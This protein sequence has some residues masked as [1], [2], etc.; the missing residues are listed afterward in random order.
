MDFKLLKDLNSISGVSGD[1][2]KILDF[3][4]DYVLK[5]QQKWAFQPKIIRNKHTQDAILLVFGKPKTAVFAHVDTVGFTAGY[6][7]DLI[8]VGSPAIKKSDILVG[9]DKLG[10]FKCKVT[11][12]DNQWHYLLDRAIERGTPLS[13]KPHF[14]ETKDFVE[15]NY[16]DNRLGVFVAL[17][18][19]ETLKNGVIAFTTYEEV[20]GGNAEV[21]ANYLYNKFSICQS[22]ICDITWVT[23]GV[24]HH[25]GVVIS[26]RDSGI[27][28]RKY[29]QKIIELAQKSGIPFQV[30]VESAGGSDGNAI[31]KSIVPMDWCFIGAPE[32]GV[33]SYTETVSKADIESM[34]LLYRYLM[35]NL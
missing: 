17:Q 28:R 6:G 18:L 19:A 14:K 16:M 13:Y 20:G 25:N 27:P 22:L 15:G 24:H 35:K 26:A 32:Y 34:I 8:K 9:E 30:E 10:E 29:I 2:E 5:N 3:I 12:V 4:Q 23:N 7:S 11:K 21:L 31:Q 33:H 1:E